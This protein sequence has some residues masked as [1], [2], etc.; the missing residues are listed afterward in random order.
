MDTPATLDVDYDEEHHSE[1]A[2]QLEAL[3]D[4]LSLHSSTSGEEHVLPDAGGSPDGIFWGIL[5]AFCIL[6]GSFALTIGDFLRRC[7]S[8]LTGASTHDPVLLNVTGRQ[9]KDDLDKDG[10]EDDKRSEG[11]SSDEGEGGSNKKLENST[12]TKVTFHKSEGDGDGTEPS[13]GK[14]KE[15]AKERDATDDAAEEA[16]GQQGDA[17]TTEAAEESEAAAAGENR[18]N[19]ETKEVEAKEAQESEKRSRRSSSSSSSSSSDEE[20]SVRQRKNA[21][22]E[23]APEGEAAAAAGEVEHKE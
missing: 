18:E 1:G 9:S 12:T 8:K 7:C 6:A 21:A 3:E 19:E 15:A 16:E 11:S 13:E 14:G 4:Q 23:T 10:A 20:S 2:A 22:A 17:K 5:A